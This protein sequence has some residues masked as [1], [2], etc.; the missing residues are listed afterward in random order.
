MT[1]IEETFTDFSYATDFL[2]GSLGEG[3][4]DE[5]T[6]TLDSGSAFIAVAACDEDCGDL[7]MQV[8][9]NGRLAGENDYDDD[10]PFVQFSSGSSGEVRI[11][12]MMVTCSVE[13]CHDSVRVIE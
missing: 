4:E 5:W 10:F 13:P 1:Y 9:I 3:D 12:V 8:R 2:D 6:V 7:D 11:S